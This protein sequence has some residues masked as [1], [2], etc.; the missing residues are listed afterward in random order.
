MEIQK[1]LFEENSLSDA[2]ELIQYAVSKY[3][4]M[5]ATSIMVKVDDYLPELLTLFVSKC[6]F[7]QISYEKLWR[8]P[9]L[10]ETPF[11]KRDFRAFCAS[12]KFPLIPKTF[13]FSPSSQTI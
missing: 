1:L 2:A 10:D 9:E 11:D 3:K 13:K 12:S 5:G 7:S 6:G 8:I 4:A